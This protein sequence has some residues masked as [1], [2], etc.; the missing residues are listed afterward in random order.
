ML[1][2]TGRLILLRIYNVSLGR[3][4]IFS[5]LLRHI[6]LR[7]LIKRPAEKRYVASSKYFDVRE[8]D[9]NSDRI[10]RGLSRG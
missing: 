9:R 6:L 4:E 7:V 2:T 1:M 3:Y 10:P 8:L 5:K